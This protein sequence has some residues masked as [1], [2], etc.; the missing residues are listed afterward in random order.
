MSRP[1]NSRNEGRT[2]RYDAA[3]SNISDAALDDRQ[4]REMISEVA[5][6]YEKA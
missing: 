4:T 2:A 3:F 5:G 1:R 6:S